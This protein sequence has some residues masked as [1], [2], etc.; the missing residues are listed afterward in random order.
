MAITATVQPDTCRKP[1]AHAASASPAR[2]S[3]CPGSTG[4]TIPTSPAAT[5]APAAIHSSAV[6]GRRSVVDRAGL[7]GKWDFAALSALPSES[8]RRILLPRF[9]AA[10]LDA[11]AEDHKCTGDNPHMADA[12]PVGTIGEARHHEQRTDQVDD[13]VRHARNPP[14]P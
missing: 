12:K 3:T 8:G 2:I 10:S 5:I 14:G 4:I 6:T 9:D 11:E 1:S 7:T 13:H